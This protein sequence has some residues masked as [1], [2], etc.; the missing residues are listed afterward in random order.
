MN[1]KVYGTDTSGHQLVLATISDFLQ[2]AQI[3]FQISEVTDVSTF[4][5]QGVESVPAIQMNDDKIIGLKSKESF[6]KSLR[7]AINQILATENYGR[8][9]KFL[10]PIDFSDVSIN[11]LSYGHRL[12]TDLGAIT[13]VLHV[14]R[15]QPKL[16]IHAEIKVLSQSTAKNR[17]DHIVKWMDTDWGS[18]ILKASLIS[19]YFKVGF[20]AEKIIA[21][22]EENTAELIIMGATGA[23]DLYHK[24]LGSVSSDVIS[25]AHSSVLLIPESAQYR[26]ISSIVVGVDQEILPLSK[27][28]KLA[29]FCIPFKATIHLVHI[30]TGGDDSLASTA[31]L[32]LQCYDKDL[33]RTE[34]IDSADILGA[35][36]TYTKANQIEV[37]AVAPKAKSMFN[38]LFK[39]SI[40]RRMSH[41]VQVPLLVLK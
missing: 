23:D 3:S 27:L 12:A 7:F 37:L 41:E 4:L 34:I 36:N 19:G 32:L 22:A 24:W 20:P 33:I 28:Q 13:Q 2:K 1:I 8:F 15:P 31:A 35:L 16:D 5:A 14:Y 18:D 30:G 6:S 10:V 21:L 26:G 38:Q 11:A 9:P 29:K 17:L 39:E 40:T 25:K